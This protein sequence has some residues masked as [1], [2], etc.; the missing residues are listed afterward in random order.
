MRPEWD[1]ASKLSTWH[2]VNTWLI[3]AIIVMVPSR[4]EFYTKCHGRKSGRYLAQLGEIREAF[5]E[6]VMV[7]LRLKGWVKGSQ[8]NWNGKDTSSREDDRKQ[9][10]EAKICM[11]CIENK[12]IEERQELKLNRKVGL[13]GDEWSLKCLKQESGMVRGV[14][15]CS[16]MD[17][18][19]L[20][21]NTSS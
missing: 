12:P 18:F 1:N 14:F 7:K 8:V 19:K 10:T 17:G 2:W 15:Q 6:E 9:I 13:W 5:L 20:I 16:M 21:K 3:F 4:R 11:W